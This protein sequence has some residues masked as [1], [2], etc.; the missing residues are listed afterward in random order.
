MIEKSILF[1]FRDEF[2]FFFLNNNKKKLQPLVENKFYFWLKIEKKK[3]T[4]L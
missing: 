4:H 2:I 3:N 1:M